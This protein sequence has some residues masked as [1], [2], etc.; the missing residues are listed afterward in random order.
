MAERST[1]PVSELVDELGLQAWL[2]E[3]EFRNPSAKHEEARNEV[4]V[5]AV[6]RDELRLQVHLGQLDAQEALQQLE[7]RWE[8]VKRLAVTSADSAG[9]AFHDVLK[10]IRDGYERITR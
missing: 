8:E 2:A 5:L 7:P 10:D 4:A 3:A 9:V 6:M 1:S